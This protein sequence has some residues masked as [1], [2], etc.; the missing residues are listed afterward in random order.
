W[1]FETRSA[2]AHV[3]ELSVQGAKQAVNIGRLGKGAWSRYGPYLAKVRSQQLE[4]VLHA[5]GASPPQLC[6]LAIYGP[7]GVEARRAGVKAAL[8]PNA[9]HGRWQPITE[10]LIAKMDADKAKFGWPGFT[11]GVT[12]DHATGAL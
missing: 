8:L 10:G 9:L 11:S 1:M 7:P 2:N 4:V 6:G 5:K 12:V 3:S